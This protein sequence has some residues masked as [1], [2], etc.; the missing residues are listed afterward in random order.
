MANGGLAWADDGMRV[1]RQV[2][3]RRDP[4]NQEPELKHLGFR[5]SVREN[6]TPEGSGDM[7]R[8]RIQVGEEQVMAQESQDVRLWFSVFVS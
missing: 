3:W 5:A 7:D 8:I 1:S 2:G 6:R 4:W